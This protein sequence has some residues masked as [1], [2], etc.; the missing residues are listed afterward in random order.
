[1][2]EQNTINVHGIHVPI[3]PLTNLEM[4]YYAKQLRIHHYR[5]NY[6]R[7]TLPKNIQQHECGVV[8]LDLI[9]NPGT[10]Y[11]CYFRNKREKLSN[12]LK[13]YHAFSFIVKC[14]LK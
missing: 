3:K 13:L 5:G 12:E 9:K 10:H 4:D 14:Y 6:M 1:M 2:N 8:N 11:V 7:D